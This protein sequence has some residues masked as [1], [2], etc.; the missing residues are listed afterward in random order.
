MRCLPLRLGPGV[1]LR[2]SLE[3]AEGLG[4]PSGFVISGLGSLVDARLRLAGAEVETLIPG[5]SEILSLSGTL[6]PDGAHLHMAIADAQGHVMGGHVAYGNTVRT[7]AEVLLVALTDWQLGRAH[8]PATGYQE[9]TIRPVS[10]PGS[11]LEDPGNGSR[12]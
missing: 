8:D 5:L 7:T 6:T 12:A 2:R 9:L 11:H 3:S 1:D 4:T 10:A